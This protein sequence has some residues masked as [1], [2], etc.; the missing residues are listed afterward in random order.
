ML[1]ELLSKSAELY[2]DYL[3]KNNKGVEIIT[4][5]KI[6]A[7]NQRK[8]KL[9]IDKRLFNP[10]EFSIC[11][12][13]QRY[14]NKELMSSEYNANIKT[15]VIY[16]PEQIYSELINAEQ[17]KTLHYIYL[18]CDLKFLVERIQKWYENNKYEIKLSER[19][20]ETKCNSV[21][22][23][24][25][26]DEDQRRAIHTTLYSPVSYIWGAPGTGKTRYVLSYSVLSCVASEKRVLIVAPTNNSLEQTLYGV[27]ATLE[28]C[29]IAHNEV[30]RLGV[31]S[32]HFAVTYPECCVVESVN[33]QI[34]ELENK[35]SL[36]NN[37]AEHLADYKCYRIISNEIIPKVTDLVTSVGISNNIQK[38]INI[39]QNQ[40][41]HIS[42]L[43]QDAY[44]KESE[45]AEHI[46][47][48]NKNSNS[49]FNK[50]LYRFTSRKSQKI[51]SELSKL[52]SDLSK[53]IDTQH[54]YTQQTNCHLEEIEKLKSKLDS[55]NVN[56]ENIIIGIRNI[57]DVSQEI[58]YLINDIS[59]DNCYSALD[60]LIT[61]KQHYKEII[62][63]LDL[64]FTTVEDIQQQIECYKLEIESLKTNSIEHRLETSKVIATTID[65]FFAN[66]ALI[67]YLKKDSMT[68]IHHIYLDEAGYCNLIKGLALFAGDVPITL[69]GDH[70]QL[71]PICEMN[72]KEFKNIENAIVF[73]WAQS[74]LAVEDILCHSTEEAYSRYMQ[75]ASFE[76]NNIEK[77]FL[78]TT[79]RFGNMLSSILNDYV[80]K[81]GFTSANNVEEL[82]LKIIN[83]KKASG[84][85]GRENIAEVN[86]IKE[87]INTLDNKD[88][89]IL[90]PYKAQVKLLNRYI[91]NA[92]EEQSVMT[93]HASQGRE[94]DIVIL[95]VCDTHNMYFTDTKNSISKG[96]QVINT[97]VSR[98]K[99]ELMLVCDAEFWASQKEQLIGELVRSKYKEYKNLHIDT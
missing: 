1:S 45:I 89:V 42:L 73:L 95:S 32:H 66:S 90:T 41:E 5:N 53:I 9:F 79:Y 75:S 12:F 80:Y 72:N 2:Y 17:N 99:R 24:P 36:L 23:P 70:M 7:V 31:P 62:E 28:D 63:Q 13:G 46:K 11:I 55:Q 81:N 29:G 27:I 88:Y 18:E 57:K 39:K 4:I 82:S 64:S 14:T 30:F 85:I 65:G 44:I 3:N 94:F 78:K 69:L 71:P 68:P 15:F 86:K 43:S 35:I 76:F 6:I 34:E 51:E 50:L 21:I 96:L 22:Y 91:P 59:S 19:T 60:K 83:T 38:Q 10:E 8:L 92:R 67:E 52:H 58:Y 61:L 25:N 47:R 93:I 20:N 40:I 97:A 37:T 26:A 98:A 87:L 74:I 33:K 16:P 49:V 77:V 54:N 56:I 48:L 84:V